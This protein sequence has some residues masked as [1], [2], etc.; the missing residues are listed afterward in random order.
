MV[1]VYQI[2][3]AGIQ[4]REFLDALLH[5]DSDPRELK[6]PTQAGAWEE[7]LYSIHLAAVSGWVNGGASMAHLFAEKTFKE[8]ASRNQELAMLIASDIAETKKSEQGTAP[9]LT[10]LKYTDDSGVERTINAY[11]D[12]VRGNSARKYLDAYIA[13]SAEYAPRGHYLFHEGAALFVASALAK[14][15]IRIPILQGQH[16]GLM[17][18][19]AAE[20][21]RYTKTTVMNLAELALK[22]C[23]QAWLEWPKKLTPQMLFKYAAGQMFDKYDALPEA[24]QRERDIQLNYCGQRCYVKDEFGAD[25]VAM[26]NPNSIRRPFHDLLL[27]WDGY[28]EYDDDFAF[29]SGEKRV[30]R[31]Y[32]PLLVAFTPENFKNVTGKGYSDL[33]QTGLNSRIAF[34]TPPGKT[35]SLAPFPKEPCSG[36]P[37]AIRQKLLYFDK[38]LSERGGGPA[39]VN[40]VPLLNK[41]DEPTGDYTIEYVHFPICDTTIHREAFEAM[42][43]Y[44][45]H[46]TVM[47]NLPEL[48]IPKELHP[49]YRRAQDKAIRIAALLAWLE[50]DGVVELVHWIAAQAIVERWRYAVHEFYDQISDQ[51]EPTREK[52]QEL[53]V[54]GKLEKSDGW[55]TFAELLNSCGMSTEQLQRLLQILIESG[56]IVKHEVKQPTRG[57][58]MPEPFIYGI[59]AYGIP[60]KWASRI[61]EEAQKEEKAS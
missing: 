45:D 61:K 35:F 10:E 7:I 24:Q 22:E 19:F 41:K 18:A 55:C 36:L 48:N 20:S 38:L 53:S 6:L 16:T 1:K 42:Q 54:L 58:R 39:I 12:P 44:S 17:I 57:P 32:I 3:E 9:P 28:P 49:W 33:W 14:R 50:N 15:R 46:L 25:L 40:K 23:G 8:L 59:P 4:A 13:W 11:L 52:K 29:S 34:L 30:Y 47:I 5:G 21:G 26:A 60:K 51:V 31:P 2:D 56:R 43:R 37:N 27:T